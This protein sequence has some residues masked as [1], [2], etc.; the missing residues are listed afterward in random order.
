M[1]GVIKIRLIIDADLRLFLLEIQKRK[2]I[3]PDDL[4]D[5]VGPAENHLHS[6]IVLLKQMRRADKKNLRL[7]V[8]L[9]TV[10]QEA[11][12]RL[13][14]GRIQF[15][16]RLTLFIIRNQL[17]CRNLSGQCL[18]APKRQNAVI[19]RSE[20]KIV[21]NRGSSA[22]DSSRLVG[23]ISIKRN[24]EPK[25]FPVSSGLL[26]IR[27]DRLKTGPGKQRQMQGHPLHCR[28]IHVILFL[29]RGAV[30]STIDLDHHHIGILKPH[31]LIQLRAPYLN[32]ISV[33]GKRIARNSIVLICQT[34]A[35]GTADIT[36]SD[37][38]NVQ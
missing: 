13:F 3:L 10:R 2:A 6:G 15:L 5:P 32:R 11:S 20:M 14:V 34:G 26:Q 28:L 12:E 36:C 16:R 35:I 9:H 38:H 24:Q 1:I 37:Q 7:R 19:V 4:S 23:M 25:R 22:A 31:G 33:D 29:L 21:L 18:K 8:F 30:K 27:P 17:P